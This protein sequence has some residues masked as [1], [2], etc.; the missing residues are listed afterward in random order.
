MPSAGPTLGQRV[1]SRD[2]TKEVP[3]TALGGGL[4]TLVAVLILILAGRMGVVLSHEQEQASKYILPW[5][6]V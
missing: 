3:S 2:G 6:F 1:F 5:T 4:G